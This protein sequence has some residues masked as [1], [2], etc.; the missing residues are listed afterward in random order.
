MFSLYPETWPKIVLNAMFS[1]SLNPFNFHFSF[2]YY[3][4]LIFYNLY[5]NGWSIIITSTVNNQLN[6]VNKYI[7]GY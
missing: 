5:T 2:I 7:F 1:N 6:I 3:N 4:I